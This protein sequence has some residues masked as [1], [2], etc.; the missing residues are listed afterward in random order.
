[1]LAIQLDDRAIFL[2][3]WRKLLLDALDADALAGQA[4][5]AVLRKVIATG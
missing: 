4:D 5:R 1:M 3:R 2:E